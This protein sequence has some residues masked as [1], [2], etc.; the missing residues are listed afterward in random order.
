[1]SRCE[2][3]D[4]T[5]WDDPDFE[6]LSPYATLLYL[7]SWTNPRCD[8]AGIYK[9]SHVKMTESK[10][11]LE[12]IPDAL[13]E[14]E[15]SRFVFYEDQVLWV[16]SRVKRLRSRS[17]QMAKAVAKD[18]RRVQ[19]SHP[20]RRRFLDEYGADPWLRDALKETYGEGNGNLSETPIDKPDSDTL[21]TPSAEGPLKGKGQ[22]PSGNGRVEL[23]DSFP[24]ELLP[25]LRSVFKVLRDLSVRHN[26][27]AVN[28]LSLAQIVMARQRLPLVRAAY[29]FAAWADGQAQPRKDVLA[30]Y[31]NWLEKTNELA[32]VERLGE[33]GLPAGGTVIPLRQTPG[34]LLRG[35]DAIWSG[36]DDAPIDATVEEDDI[37]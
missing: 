36:D 37:A 21:S 14:L 23:P 15:R 10:V 20:L 28:P 13:A 5:I 16:R 26:A 24:R 22:E 4:N 2:D 12:H 25:H 34:S 33:D 1:M 27:K 29:D 6:D 18:I 31:R 11:P 17:P 8:M 3:I 9:V 7:W 35:L 19:P 32:T 30:G